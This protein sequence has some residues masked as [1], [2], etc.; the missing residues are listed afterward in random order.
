MSKRK[1]IWSDEEKSVACRA[2][3]EGLTGTDI[4]RKFTFK[5]KQAKQVTNLVS[6]LKGQ[7][8]RLLTHEDPEALCDSGR[9]LS[10]RDTG[11]Q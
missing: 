4:R 9:I 6:S 10:V 1:D 7:H 8:P 3:A 11:T 5:G 2:I